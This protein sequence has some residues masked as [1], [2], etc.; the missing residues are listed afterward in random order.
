[1]KIMKT[2]Q[3]VEEDQDGKGD[4]SLSECAAVHGRAIVSK[5]DGVVRDADDAEDKK[6]QY[7]PQ[8]TQD[9]AELEHI[10]RHHYP[11]SVHPLSPQHPALTSS[12]PGRL[13]PSI[14]KRSKQEPEN[15]APPR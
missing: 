3:D 15:R 13:L 1:M 14:K 7:R 6:D 10:P 4:G 12:T 9:S 2:Y 8:P 5:H 11:R